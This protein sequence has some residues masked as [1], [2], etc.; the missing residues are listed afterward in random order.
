MGRTNGNS[1]L[2]AKERI[3]RERERQVLA[4]WK[5]YREAVDKADREQAEANV[6]LMRQA[7]MVEIEP[8]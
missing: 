1:V 6:A 5:N 7:G 3:D 8:L 4:A 2:R